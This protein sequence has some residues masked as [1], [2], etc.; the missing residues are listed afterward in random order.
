MMSSNSKTLFLAKINPIEKFNN[1]NS[2]NQSKLFYLLSDI[3]HLLE[4][5]MM[6]VTKE[7]TT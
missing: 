2:S 4:S 1:L 5:K 3:H 7:I 6:P